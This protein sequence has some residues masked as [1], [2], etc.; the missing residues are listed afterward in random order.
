MLLCSKCGREAF[1]IRNLCAQCAPALHKKHAAWMGFINNAEAEYKKATGK[2][3]LEDWEG[4]SKFLAKTSAMHPDQA[5]ELMRITEE[6]E[7]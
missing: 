2:T 3:S 4:F 7:E 5:R 6:A 1:L